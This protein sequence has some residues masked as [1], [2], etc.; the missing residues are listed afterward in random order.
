MNRVL[1]KYRHF[2]N[3][4]CSHFEYDEHL[5]ITVEQSQR[6][7]LEGLFTLIS[8][9]K[10]QEDQILT[11]AESKIEILKL[12]IHEYSSS[13]PKTDKTAKLESQLQLKENKIDDLNLSLTDLKNK[14]DQDKTINSQII[15]KHGY[16]LTEK[17]DLILNHTQTLETMKKNILDMR[18]NLER[19]FKDNEEKDIE[20]E[21]LKEQI[22]GGNS[23]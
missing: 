6:P 13:Q 10:T 9:L 19:T 1:E 15:E 17:N 5:D 3:R 22:N 21:Y 16:Q 8:H 18:D 7:L 20:I 4:V 11:T 2:A 23:L 12:K 14:I